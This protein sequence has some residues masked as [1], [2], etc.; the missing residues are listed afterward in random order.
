M[1]IQKQIHL[2]AY[3]RGFH[4]ITAL[5][6]Q[7]LPKLH[8]SPNGTRAKPEDSPGSLRGVVPQ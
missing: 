5:I 6:R 7:E 8:I 3:P 1:I 2:P 4:L